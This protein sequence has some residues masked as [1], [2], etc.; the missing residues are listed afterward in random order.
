[1]NDVVE[2]RQTN[3]TYR[4]K[5][6]IIAGNLIDPIEAVK[7][8]INHILMT[9]RYSNP[10]YDN[11]YGV[12]LEQLIGKDIWYIKAR[13]QSILE[14]ALMQDDRIIAV[15]VN[16]VEK[17]KVQNNACVIDFDVDTIYG[18][19]GGNQIVV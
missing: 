9:E 19:I 5:D 8:A 11:S 10:I 18:S 17:S 3:K 13:I 4:V 16:S 2:I 6:D 1:M 14:D 15:N 12:E 7:Q